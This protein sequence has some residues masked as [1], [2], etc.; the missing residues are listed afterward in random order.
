MTKQDNKEDGG[1]ER[2]S[3]S[4][5]PPLIYLRVS[6]IGQV[7]TDRDGEGFSIAAS[8]TP[9]SARPNISVRTSWRSTPTLA[10]RH[11]KPTDPN[12]R[13][14]C[15]D[16]GTSGISTSSSSTRSTGWPAT[17]VTTSRSPLPSAQAGAQLVSVTENI[18]ETPSGMLLHGI[19]SSIA[20]F[21]CQNL[22]TE[23]IK[24]T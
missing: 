15:R 13:R 6:S 2:R 24:G 4:G 16:F 14:C 10:N 19:M 8:R 11:A 12:C 21:Y 18:D 22:S 9:V 23:I 5:R 7:N 17:E 1:G 3:H 20:E